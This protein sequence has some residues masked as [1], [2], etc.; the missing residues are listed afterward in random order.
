[1]E[2]G[3]VEGINKPVSRLVQGSMMLNPEDLETSFGLLDAVYGLGCTTFDL[4]HIYGGGNADRVFGKWM[5][6][7]GNREKLVILEKGAHH[8]SDRRRVTPF[9][10]TA[11]LY[12]S[13]ARLQTDHVELYLLHRDDPSVPVGPIVE[14]LNEHHAEGRIQVFG[15]SNWTV[16]RVQEANEYAAEKGLVP[17]G[18]SSP[19]L[20]LAE[21]VEEPWAECVSISGPQ[22]EASRAWYA[23]TQMPLFTWSSVAQGFFSGRVTRETAD[24]VREDFPESSVRSYWHEQNFSRLDR[25]QELAAEKGLGVTQIALA[26]VHN[27]PLNLFTLVGCRSRAEC[28]ANVDALTLRLTPEEMAW[29]DLRGDSRV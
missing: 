10:I 16:E 27:L 8:N 5:A 23:K 6:E 21:Q 7:R 12:D 26:Y 20:S 11:D 22:G 3:Q 18:A 25:V 24:S 28:Q 13:L 2:Y 29:L 17:F 15:G 9:D 1:M 19:N 14:V 4:A